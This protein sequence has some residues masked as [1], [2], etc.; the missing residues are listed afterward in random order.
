MLDNAL[1]A[2]EKAGSGDKFVS[3]HA[4]QVK[5]CLLLEVRNN[6]VLKDI[7]DICPAGRPLTGGRG[8]G[9]LNIRDTVGKYDG[10]M[11]VE[12]EDGVFTISLLL[13]LNA[14]YDM[15]QTF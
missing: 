4:G 10:A 2:C 15:K 7:K 14:A 12:A 8:I 5:K 1:A 6:T 3:I 9:L 13:P 11:H